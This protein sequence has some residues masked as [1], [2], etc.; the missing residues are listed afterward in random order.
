MAL[1]GFRRVGEFARERKATLAGFSRNFS[2][3]LKRNFGRNVDVNF[4]EE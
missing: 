4:V 3:N 1:D 2:R